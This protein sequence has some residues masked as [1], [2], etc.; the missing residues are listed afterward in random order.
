M[1]TQ[2]VER[3]LEINKKFYSEFAHSFSETRSSSQ[4]R[5]DRI[6]AYVG[7]SVKVLDVGCGNGRLAERIDREG[8]HVEYL[9]VDGS[10]ELVGV[11]AARKSRLLRVKADYVVADITDSEWP[12]L[13]PGAPYDVVVAL[14]VLHHVPSFDLR[15]R[16]LEEIRSLLRPGGQ[17][18]MTNW[19][20]ERN[21]RLRRKVVPWEHIGIDASALE[22]GD[23]LL[24]WERG[25]VGYRYCHLMT[26]Q[27]VLRA[28]EL[29]GFK[30]MK[31]YYADADLNLY[32][33]LQR[34]VDAPQA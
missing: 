17:F 16:V 31:Q 10:V 13:I 7:D 22:H 32:S 33:I 28:A 14:A 29:A 25:G 11:A 24:T 26:I 4:T 12:G 30:V 1:N 18:V 21:E 6:V 5:L 19:H 8:R 23:A 34:P 2:L 3:L 20:F 15:T 9:G 27:E